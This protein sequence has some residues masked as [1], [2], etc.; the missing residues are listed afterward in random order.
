MNPKVLI[1]GLLSLAGIVAGVRL[2]FHGTDNPE[3]SIPPASVN[4][5][6]FIVM[7]D[8]SDRIILPGQVAADK[9]M[10]LRSFEAFE[11][12]AR[13]AK[14]IMTSRD[15]FQVCI[16]PQQSLGFDKEEV[17]EQLTLDLSMIN[18]AEKLKVLQAFKQALP[19]HLDAL[20][21]KAD[22]GKNTQ[23]YSGSN[24]WQFFNETLAFL[25]G[26]E[27]VTKVLVVTDGYFDFEDDNMARKSSGNQSTSS[28]HFIGRLRNNSK[29]KSMIDDQGFGILPVNKPF[30]ELSVCVAGVRSKNPDH[31]DEMEMLAYIWEKWLSDSGI[32]GTNTLLIPYGSV[33]VM[34][35]KMAGFFKNTV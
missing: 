27:Y 3:T 26:P 31:L 20:Y 29:W 24:I 17:S 11:W 14:L 2:L 13:N 22:K 10:I 9:A 12:T 1:F 32:K 25:S 34:N 15:R 21:A 23:A 18:P 6:Q 8:L 33:S 28:N 5:E 30:H 4:Q 35:S 16:A 19:G 7:L